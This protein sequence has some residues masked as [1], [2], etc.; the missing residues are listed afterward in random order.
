METYSQTKIQDWLSLF[1]R[2]IL[3][4]GF[5]ILLARLIDL[6][7]IKGGYYRKLAEENRIRR[8]PILAPRG[9]ILARGGEVLVDNREVKKKVVFGRDGYEKR[10]VSSD[11]PREEIFSEWSRE[12]KF[13]GKLAHITGFLGE[14]EEGEVGKIRGECPQK[15]IRKLGDLVGK[16]G[17]EREYECVLSGIDGE[18]LVEVDSLGR[19][20][21][22]LGRR[23]A[24]SGEDIKT[25]IDLG[26]QEEV[27]KIFEAAKIPEGKR[28]VVIVTD[29]RGEVLAFYSSPSF[30]PN[31]FGKKDKVSEVKRYL[32]DKNL[33]LFNRVISGRYHPGSTFKPIVAIAGLEEGKIDGNFVYEDPGV[34]TIKTLYGDFSFSNWY[35]NQYGRR[36][37]A[38]K[39]PRAIARSTDTFFYKV[40]EMV[41]VEKLVEWSA[42]FGLD[43]ATGI[44]LPGEIEGLIPSPSWKV[45]V[46]GERWFLG[47]TYHMSI[48]QGD[49]ALTPVGLNSAIAAIA[50]GGELCT[51]RV[52]GRGECRILGI[53]RENID[54]VRQG[55]TEAC[56]TG[57]TGF[58]FFDFSD[59]HPGVRVACK[60]GT[61]ETD[62]GKE[63]HAWFTAFA[64]S[65]SPEIVATVMIENGG[66]GSRTAGPIARGI[67][68]YWFSRSGN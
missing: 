68:D 59:K 58:T 21:R 48:G 5:L 42:K 39:L 18:E 9:R 65:D 13:A 41:G 62:D 56:S 54:L 53:K 2:G 52:V 12:Y 19:K 22:I 43:K 35:Y 66:E 24:V 51:P 15:G 40:G 36:E 44:D 47:N 38:I 28:G 64:P 16:T 1:L 57:G 46:K 7:I 17:L 8:I 63:P 25:N 60:T 33:P 29:V 11:T 3:V 23:E 10:E 31:L 6:Q 61:A 50:N 27:V 4:V 67:F 34:I 55:M 26:L 32:E 14:S 20:V 30:D 45:K 37:G 49:I